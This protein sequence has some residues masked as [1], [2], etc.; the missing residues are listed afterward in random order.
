MK[1]RYINEVDHGLVIAAIIMVL[2]GL[3]LFACGCG[4]HD[5]CPARGNWVPSRTNYFASDDTAAAY[6]P[7]DTTAPEF[8]IETVSH[9]DDCRLCH[10]TFFRKRNVT[11]NSCF[12]LQIQGGRKSIYSSS[13]FE[14]QLPL[15]TYKSLK[16]SLKSM[17][18]VRYILALVCFSILFYHS[19]LTV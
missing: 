19:F 7:R 4:I 17:F 16:I 18:G 1:N 11:I 12:D 10:F 3:I 14:E 13:L 6:I 2:L 9:R 15:R 5:D 8:D